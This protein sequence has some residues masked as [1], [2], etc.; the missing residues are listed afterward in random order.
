[1]SKDLEKYRKLD[2]SVRWN[3]HSDWMNAAQS[4][5]YTYISEWLTCETAKGVSQPAL[6]KQAKVTKQS[7]AIK[8]RRFQIIGNSPGG[9]NN[10]IN[11]TGL[12]YHK[13]KNFPRRYFVAGYVLKK[14]ETEYIYRIFRCTKCNTRLAPHNL[15]LTHNDCTALIREHLKDADCC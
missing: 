15:W 13:P 3:Y 12:F 7:I 5:G 6:A 10:N 11:K 9:Y 1:M 14:S 2:N 4:A 8:F